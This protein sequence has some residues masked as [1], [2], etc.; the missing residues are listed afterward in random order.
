MVYGA[1]EPLVG[2]FYWLIIYPVASTL[3]GGIDDTGNMAAATQ[4]KT[5]GTADKLCDTPGRFPGDDIVL[6]R[7]NHIDVL[8]NLAEINRYAFQDYLVWHDE[9]VLV[10]GIAQ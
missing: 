10:I 9:I 6:L 3:A 7:T 5:H 1:L 4:G 2:A 8:A